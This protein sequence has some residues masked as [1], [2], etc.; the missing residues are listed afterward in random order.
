MIEVKK[1]SELF[2]KGYSFNMLIYGPPGVGKTTFATDPK[3]VLLI[4]CENRG[5]FVRNQGTGV[6]SL[7][8]WTDFEQLP[9][10][11]KSHT[12]YRIVVIDPLGELFDK[13]SEDLRAKGYRNSSGN[14]T[15]EGWGMAK[16][17]FKKTLR[18]LRDMDV[19]V[20]CISHTSEDKDEERLV[21]RPYLPAKLHID[22]CALM[23]VVGFMEDGK[24]GK[25][26]KGV[27]RIRFRP[28]DKVYA[29]D[30]VGALPEVVENPTFDSVY[31]LMK[32]N[33]L[34]RIDHA[35]AKNQSEF[36]KDLDK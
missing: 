22:V 10:F 1:P 24:S 30:A 9:A 16:E 3:D 31:S 19:N 11:I 33:V 5:K 26:N 23:D 36:E 8:N 25:D 21:C 7:K 17:K 32:D 20:I 27:R 14:L 2:E 34:A 4:D 35:R 28:N 12:N 29:K 6:V 13:L 15:L 18:E